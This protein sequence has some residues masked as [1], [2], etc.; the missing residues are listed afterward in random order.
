MA[1]YFGDDFFPFFY[2]LSLNNHKEWF[3]Q[4]RKR[5]ETVIKKPFYAFTQDLINAIKKYEP[6]LD[7]QVKHAVFRINRDI[8]FSKNKSPYNQHISAMISAKGR[9]DGGYSG[10]Y[11]HFGLQGSSLGGGAYKPSKDQLYKIRSGIAQDPEELYRLLKSKNFQEKYPEGIKGEKNKRLPK[12]FNESV[13]DHPILFNKQFYFMGESQENDW[14]L[15][16]D[17]LDFCMD[18]YLAQK[19]L[20]EYLRALLD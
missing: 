4:N 19:D 8:R 1:A 2:E 14:A 16:E 7:Q 13:V 10:F 11:F 5:Y 12:E 18:Y 9:K 3:D 6:Q 17:L 20:A 15:R